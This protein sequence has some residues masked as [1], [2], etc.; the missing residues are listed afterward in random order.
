MSRITNLYQSLIQWPL[1]TAPIRGQ[2]LAPLTSLKAGGKAALWVQVNNQKELELVVTQIL[3]LGLDWFL[4][5]KGSNLICSSET[6]DGV[7]LQLGG[8][9]T[10]VTRDQ[11]QLTAG[12]AAQDAKVAKVARN[13]GLTG[14]EWLVTIPGTLG[15]AVYMNAG[16]HHVEIKDRL[17][18]ALVYQPGVGAR[19]LDLGDFDFGYRSSRLQKTNEILLQATF[20]LSE[21]DPLVIKAQEQKLLEARR[22][23]QP[24]GTKTFGSM[25]HNP[26]GHSAWGLIQQ[27]G[28]Q[29]KQVGNFRVS[30]KHANFMENMGSGDSKGLLELIKL[31]Q[32]EVYQTTG[33]HLH[34][35]G[36]LFPT[37]P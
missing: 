29:G 15:G 22:K 32:T 14:L 24:V 2:S 26:P 17:K 10:Q 3:D 20:E 9:F 23:T 19:P 13:Q 34:L 30:P 1:E 11:N 25:F 6:Y 4:I 27:A 31:V 35:E 7:L 16:A 36:K 8:D 33:V 28:L 12:G 18:S 37:K 5:G 21:A